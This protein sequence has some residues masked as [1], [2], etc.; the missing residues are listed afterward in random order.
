M[1]FDHDLVTG[2]HR[3]RAPAA[4]T[5]LR[6][7]LHFERP[8]HWLASAVG[9]HDMKPDMRIGP[10]EFLHHAGLGDELFG[11]E[12]RKGMVCKGCAGQQ[13]NARYSADN[14]VKL[15]PDRPPKGGWLE[16]DE[17]YITILR[18]ARPPGRLRCVELP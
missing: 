1:K 17:Y 8:F 15:H 3:V 2:L 11:V 14:N 13:L 7:R 5:C 4:G 18:L 16:S 6:C 12:H 10:L 9:R